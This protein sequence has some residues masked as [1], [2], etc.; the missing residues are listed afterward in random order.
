MD[1][2]SF[3]K[4]RISGTCSVFVSNTQ[5]NSDKLTIF[6]F[7]ENEYVHRKPYMSTCAAKMVFAKTEHHR[8]VYFIAAVNI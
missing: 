6:I 2:F 5:P 4:N 8:F 7:A 3:C 1:L